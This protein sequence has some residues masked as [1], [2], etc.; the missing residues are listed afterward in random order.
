[1]I[2]PEM[3][4]AFD[5]SESDRL[6]H[7]LWLRK[8]YFQMERLLDVLHSAQLP[9]GFL[10]LGVGNAET[11]YWIAITRPGMPNSRPGFPRRDKAL[12][13]YLM[14]W[15]AGVRNHADGELM[16]MERMYPTLRSLPPPSAGRVYQRSRKE[17]SGNWL[18]RAFRSIF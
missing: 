10:D 14:E 11:E 16:E 9:D 1:M 5:R 6:S 17:K 4:A 3:F 18:K 2:T 12:V 13:D 15:S 8:L 7:Y